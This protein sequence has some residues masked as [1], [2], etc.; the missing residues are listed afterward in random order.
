M[1]DLTFGNNILPTDQSSWI[2]INASMPSPG[3]LSMLAGSTASCTITSILNSNILPEAFRVKVVSS[4]YSSSYAPTAYVTASIVYSNDDTY[5]AT[6]PIINIDT[7][8]EAILHPAVK[9]YEEEIT[10]FKSVAIKVRSDVAMT[11]S[12]CTL[13]R[14]SNDPVVL[15]NDYYGTKITTDQGL[16]ITHSSGNAEAVFNANTFSMRAKKDGVMKNMVYFDATS[17]KYVFDGTL[18]ADTIEALQALI[19]NSFY[20]EKGYIAELT[21]DELDTSDKI[22]RYLDSDT[23]DVNYQKI[24]DQQHKFISAVASS[25]YT[26]AKTRDNQSLYWTDATRVAAT[27]TV[28]AY[29]VYVYNYTETSKLEIGFEYVG[30]AYI[31]KLILG[32]STGAGGSPDSGRAK[33]YK[34]S[35]GFYID[36]FN[37]LDGTKNTFKITDDGGVSFSSLPTIEHRDITLVE[38]W[39]QTWVQDEVPTEAKANDVW[40]DT[41]DYTRYDRTILS[42][43][44]TLATSDNEFILLEGTFAVTLHSAT[45]AGI[46]KKFYN[47]GTGI[48]TLAGTING[49]TNMLL[50]PGESIELITD[51]SGWRY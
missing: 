17:G 8:L 32:T 6:M 15:N 18:T 44:T 51:G 42:A 3:V 30:T 24:F 11:V 20:A 27:T 36:Y 12:V 10:T 1:A 13:Q 37:S 19:T 43:N 35:T 16:V 31:P 28:T 14:S 23:S 4:V 29:P 25:G 40:V 38:G 33:I 50:Y 47:K 21:V 7:G 34:D 45:T 49:K 26:Q 9:N 22:Q 2:L 48:V 46:I 39:N 41:D 5:E